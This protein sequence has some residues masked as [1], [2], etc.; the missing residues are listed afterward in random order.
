MIGYCQR[1]GMRILSRSFRSVGGRHKSATYPSDTT[2]VHEAQEP[3]TAKLLGQQ[4]Q[5]TGSLF[6]GLCRQSLCCSGARRIKADT[7]AEMSESYEEVTCSEGEYEEEVIE[8]MESSPPKRPPHPLFGGGGGAP[9]NSA[10]LD[11]I[12]ARGSTP[13]TSQGS[14]A[15]AAAPPKPRA[16]PPPPAPKPPKPAGEMSIAEQVAMMAAKRQNRMTNGAAPVVSE[17]PA[18]APAP[19]PPKPAPPAP[20]PKPA[21]APAATKKKGLF[22]GGSKQKEAG[23]P[24]K[25]VTPPPAPAPAPYTIKS[26]VPPPIETAS[27]AA[28]TFSQARLK[29]T[30]IRQDATPAAAEPEETAPSAVPTTTTT[31]TTTTTKTKRVTKSNPQYDEVEYKVG[32]FCT[33]M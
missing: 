11:Q 20:Q 4:Q 1:G 29:P 28:P 3:V 32:C 31:R 8:E 16:P 21:A 25:K 17:T 10:L 26:Y 18:V 19:P 6:E 9:G 23:A 12:K 22:G 27:P 24:T 7:M 13:A 15:G 5:P 2:L 33:V 14:G 30:G